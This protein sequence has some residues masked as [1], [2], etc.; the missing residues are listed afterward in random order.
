M[1]RKPR[2]ATAGAFYHAINRAVRRV[3]LFES[4]AEYAAFEGRLRQGLQQTTLR[5]LAY[6][7]MPNHFHLVVWSQ[8]DTDLPVFM[9]RITSGHA[10]D[11]HAWRNT[12]GTGHVYQDRYKAVRIEDDEQLLTTC[13]YIERNAKKAKLVE[14]AEDWRWSSLWRRQNHCVDGLLS[15]WP[16]PVPSDWIQIVNADPW[17][18]PPR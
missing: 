17:T 8:S 12:A 10:R 4:D 18:T 15:N 7:A 6:S 1:P 9:R 16:L 13:R 2:G 14:R 11:W 5:L 3:A